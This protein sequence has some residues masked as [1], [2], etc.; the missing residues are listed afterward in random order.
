MNLRPMCWSWSGLSEMVG[1]KKVTLMDMDLHVIV[2][3]LMVQ[4]L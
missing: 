1:Q 4:Y 3:L 2:E